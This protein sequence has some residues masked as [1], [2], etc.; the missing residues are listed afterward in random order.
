MQWSKVKSI[1]IVILLIVDVFLLFSFGLRTFDLWSRNERM[2]QNLRTVLRQNEVVLR[3]DF[4]LPQEL[5]LPQLEV[6][7]NRMVE[8][9]TAIAL[10]GGLVISSPDQPGRFESPNGVAYWTDEEGLYAEIRL[11]DYQKPSADR[12]Q[13]YAEEILKMAEINTDGLEWTVDGDCAAAHFKTAGVEVF[14]RSLQVEF[15][16]DHIQITGLWTFDTPYITKTN[17]YT[18][19]N[20]IDALLV[21]VQQVEVSR[22]DAMTGGYYAFYS[23]GRFQL[24]PAWRIESDKGVYYVD[25]LKKTVI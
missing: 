3:E 21:F 7:R 23:A 1:L 13:A 12:V 9:Q 24:T 22:I 20:P 16:E 15:L 14:N 10:L 17:A 2:E 19:C 11:E 25:S 4:V 5:T 6:D 18:T 8:E